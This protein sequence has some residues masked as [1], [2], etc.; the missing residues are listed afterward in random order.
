MWSAATPLNGFRSD[1][2]YLAD[3]KLWIVTGTSGSDI[4]LDDG[5]TWKQFDTGNYNAISFSANAVW[6]VGPK[7]AIARLNHF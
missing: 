2:K 1:V 6:A 4:S 5:R 3:H 7:G